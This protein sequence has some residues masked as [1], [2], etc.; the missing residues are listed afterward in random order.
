M[1]CKSFHCDICEY[2]TTRKDSFK[3]HMQTYKHYI[4]SNN[5]NNH[6]NINV[7]PS[8][9]K[10]YQCPTCNKIYNHRQSMYKHSKLCSSQENNSEIL[11]QNNENKVSTIINNENNEKLSK[12]DD[13]KEL[14]KI[15]VEQNTNLQTMIKEMIPKIGNNNNNTIIN[16]NKINMTLFLEQQCKDAPNMKDFIAGLQIQVGD[17]LHTKDKGIVNGITHIFLNGLKQ[18][19][20]YQRP[21]HCTDSK[22]QTLYIKDDDCWAHG[23]EGRKIFS[24]AI[25]EVQAKHT[26]TIPEWEK[27]HPN[28]NNNDNLTED[29]MKIVKYSTQF[30]DTNSNDENKIIRAIAKEV[31]LDKK[32]LQIED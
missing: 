20:I 21:I 29:Y 22:R 11:I 14:I 19:D 13:Y 8:I 10:K 9:I 1:L 32:Q 31:T 2:K 26:K 5:L 30:I 27:Q 6:V 18:L 7:Q 17:L 15:L 16:N 28:W 4:N 25:Q 12:K 3:K 24:D 23:A